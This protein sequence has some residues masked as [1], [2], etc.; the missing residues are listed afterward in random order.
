[1]HETSLEHPLYKVFDKKK[2][3]CLSLSLKN[4]PQFMVKY[5]NK[6]KNCLTIIIVTESGSLRKMVIGFFARNFLYTKEFPE[7]H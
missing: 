1:M 7:G 4:R 2:L 5:T 6:I 3:K